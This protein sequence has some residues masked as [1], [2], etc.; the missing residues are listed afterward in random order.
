MKKFEIIKNVI[1]KKTNNLI[2]KHF[3]Q[4]C[5]HIS[6]K[7]FKNNKCLK[8]ADANLCKKLTKLRK[9]NRKAFSN[10]YNTMQISNEILK[11]GYNEKIQSLAAR[12]LNISKSNFALRNVQFR[13]DLPKENQNTYGWHQDNAYYKYNTLAKNGVIFW[14][15]LVN[16]NLNNGT[17]IIK[18]D[19]FNCDIS[20]S[21]KKGF[22]K[23]LF[24]S[25]QILVKPNILKKFGKEISVDVNQNDGLITTAG[26]FHKSGINNS[27]H[28]RF[29][30]IVR[31]NNIFSN[32]FIYK[33]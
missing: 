30:L 10:I 27:D 22:K 6:P 21:S 31:F 9:K 18:P 3:I 25:E 1:D 24:S 5:K 4:V 7:V 32:D 23:N 33:R 26:I 2:F 11:V 17:L 16:A 14:I 28:V 13:I 12:Y 15:P 8:F 20:C 29:S 19:S